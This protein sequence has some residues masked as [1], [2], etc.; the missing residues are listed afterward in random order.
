M[1]GLSRRI[2]PRSLLSST[3]CNCI[4]WAFA[5]LSKPA[6]LCCA[7]GWAHIKEPAKPAATSVRLTRGHDLAPLIRLLFFV[8]FLRSEQP[9]SLIDLITYLQIKDRN[10][11]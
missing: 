11:F 8:G 2:S 6:P 9:S 1:T 10:L 3:V 7:P 4:A 5:Q